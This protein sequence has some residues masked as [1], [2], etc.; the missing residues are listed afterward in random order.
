MPDGNSL[1]ADASA[2]LDETVSLNFSSIYL[3]L[4]VGRFKIHADILWYLCGK[5]FVYAGF[6]VRCQKCDRKKEGLILSCAR[7][8]GGCQAW[9][10][11]EI[12]SN[13]IRHSMWPAWG[14]KWE[15]GSQLRS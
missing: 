4:R 8:A 1:S 15:R 5:P 6:G 2:R 3:S 13:W 14:D 12:I 11:R 7:Q 10:E 9:G